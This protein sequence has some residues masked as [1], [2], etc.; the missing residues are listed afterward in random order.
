[1]CW[2]PFDVGVFNHAVDDICIRSVIIDDNEQRLHEAFQALE[3]LLAAL[4]RIP[5]PV[6]LCQS[7]RSLPVGRQQS[8]TSLR[9]DITG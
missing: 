6:C 8:V 7:M 5:Y 2:Q 4:V 9:R 1:M 3:I